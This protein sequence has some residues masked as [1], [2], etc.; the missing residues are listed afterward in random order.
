MEELLDRFE[1]YRLEKK[2]PEFEK[3]NIEFQSI[4]WKAA[5]NEDLKELLKN[6]FN[7]VERFKVL[8]RRYPDYTKDVIGPHK[9]ILE[10]IIQ[11]EVDKAEILVRRHIASFGDEIIALLEKDTLPLKEAV[12]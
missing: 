10:A 11:K 5:N 6:I 3:A 9:E 2:Y 7:R 1:K 4:I 12:S 8:T